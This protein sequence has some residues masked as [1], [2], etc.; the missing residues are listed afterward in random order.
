MA[1][2]LLVLYW[3]RL[4]SADASARPATAT[5]PVSGDAHTFSTPAHARTN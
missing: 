4:W 5:S 2:G 3:I 1:T